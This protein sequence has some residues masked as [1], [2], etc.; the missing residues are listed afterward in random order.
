M[1]IFSNSLDVV[2]SNAI[3]Q[4]DAGFSRSL[5]GLRIA[6]TLT[7]FHCLG[8]C[9]SRKAAFKINVNMTNPLRKS[10]VVAWSFMRVKLF[11]YDGFYFARAGEFDWLVASGVHIRN[12]GGPSVI[13]LE[14]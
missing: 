11:P 2:E 8:M 3:G 13:G 5:P 10:S 9:C 14:C 1:K 4:Y 7:C 6:I 12:K